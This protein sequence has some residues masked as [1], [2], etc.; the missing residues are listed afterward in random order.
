L[1]APSDAPRV[2]VRIAR[3]LLT[4]VDV[5]GGLRLV[6]VGVSGLAD[7]TQDDLFGELIAADP[8]DDPDQTTEEPA[9]SAAA[10]RTDR[11]WVAGRDVDHAAWGQGWVQGSGAGWVTVRFETRDTPP[12]R[13]RSFRVTDPDLRPASPRGW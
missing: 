5:S 1:P 9:Q 12:G 13:V 10:R 4:D 7:W 8:Q 2:V 11:P 6:G 3:Q